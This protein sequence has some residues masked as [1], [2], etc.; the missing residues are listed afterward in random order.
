MARENGPMTELVKLREKTKADLDS[1]KVV[2]EQT[3]DSVV[4][5]L[6]LYFLS[7][8]KEGSDSLR[9]KKNGA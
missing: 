5:G 6:V 8:G 7:K 4:G 2:E 3:Y 1:L 9:A